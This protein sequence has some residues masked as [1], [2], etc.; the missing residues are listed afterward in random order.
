M[1]KVAS[2][3]PS[4]QTSIARMEALHHSR[5]KLPVDVVQAAV[6]TIVVAG[7]PVAV[8]DGPVVVAVDAANHRDVKERT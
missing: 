7:V 2:L 4:L 6:T 5:R 8:A 1:R 3:P